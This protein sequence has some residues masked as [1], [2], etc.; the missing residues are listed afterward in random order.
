MIWSTTGHRPGISTFPDTDL[1][2]RKLVRLATTWIEA[3]E[4]RL[5]VAIT[6]MALG[7][8]Q[9]FAQACAG[10]GI[11]FVAAV[12]FVGQEVRWSAY[13]QARYR[14]LIGKAH[15]VEIVSQSDED[16]PSAYYVRNRWMIDNSQSLVCLYD[17]R[18]RGGT[19]YTVAY[20]T[21]KQMPVENLWSK[22]VRVR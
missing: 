18:P 4:D 17:G 3:S 11:P 15:R 12:P 20:A 7:W 1:Y 5:A 14:R 19:Y 16:L 6:G 13:D 10:Y 2:F 22:W 9:A 21:K 8:D